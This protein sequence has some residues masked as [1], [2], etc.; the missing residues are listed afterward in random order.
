MEASLYS[1][2]ALRTNNDQGVENGIIH[3]ALGVASEAGEIYEAIIDG[4]E[5]EVIEELGDIMWF[6]NLMCHYK[7]FDLQELIE[8]SAKSK[9]VDVFIN[10]PG[11]ACSS[12]ELCDLVKK[13][14]AYGK[15]VDDQKFRLCLAKIVQWVACRAHM[16]GLEGLGDVFAKNIAKLSARYPAGTF[17][18]ESA[19]SRDKEREYAAIDAA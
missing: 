13:T 17:S 8:Y 2:L 12:S 5:T 16:I 9:E 1:E 7:N 10:Y 11:I 19:L 4:K 6:V 14:H 15:P 3:A 18:V